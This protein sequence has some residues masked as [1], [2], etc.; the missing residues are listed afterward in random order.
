MIIRARQNCVS[1]SVKSRRSRKATRE[2]VSNGDSHKPLVLTDEVLKSYLGRRSSLMRQRSASR[3]IGIATGLGWTPVGG[4]VL[5]VEAT[6]MPGKG[7][8]F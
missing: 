3:E 4:E 1:L 8:L 6:R 7:A 2:L 5:F